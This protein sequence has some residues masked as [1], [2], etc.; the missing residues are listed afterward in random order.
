MP[1]KTKLAKTGIMKNAA[2]FRKKAMTKFSTN[3]TNKTG[4]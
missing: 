2:P 4:I 3:Q 1:N